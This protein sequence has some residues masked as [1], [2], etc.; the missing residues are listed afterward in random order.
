MDS[1]GKYGGIYLFCSFWVA[2][3]VVPFFDMLLMRWY[4]EETEIVKLLTAEANV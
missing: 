1:K 4:Y 3:T 2:V